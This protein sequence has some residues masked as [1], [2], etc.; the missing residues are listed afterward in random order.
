MA[1]VFSIQSPTLP[2]DFEPS[3]KNANSEKFI[4]GA[5]CLIAKQQS[6]TD[7]GP[8]AINGPHD[9]W[10]SRSLSAGGEQEVKFNS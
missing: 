8:G 1:G 9:H 3:E 5:Q 2:R 7:L 6:E 10:G 4:K